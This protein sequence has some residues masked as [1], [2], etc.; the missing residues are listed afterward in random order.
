MTR[1]D[2]HE[3]LR[4]EVEI[5]GSSDRAFGLVFAG[6]FALVSLWP[7]RWGQ[8]LRL[9]AL[10]LA[11]LCV[12]VALLAPAALSPLNRAW[13]ALGRLLQ[14]LVSPVILALLFYLVVTPIGLLMRCLGKTPL[15]LGLDPAARTYWIDRRP[16]G[17]APETMKNQF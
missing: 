3:D 16:P 9:W 10:G 4:R 6:F 14:R 13:T 1:P 5:R 15:R 17:P 7:L 12:L 8:P 11:A 2:L